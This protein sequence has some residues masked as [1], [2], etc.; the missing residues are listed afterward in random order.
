MPD[1]TRTRNGSTVPRKKHMHTAFGNAFLLLSSC[2]WGTEKCIGTA[3]RGG[4]TT[5]SSCSI[6]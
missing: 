4:Y 2:R 1:F 6:L 3:P 5:D